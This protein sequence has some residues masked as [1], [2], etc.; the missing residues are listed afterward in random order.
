MMEW[1]PYWELTSLPSPRVL[2][3]HL[4]FWLQPQDMLAKK[5]KIVFYYR[6]FK[7]VA[8]SFYYHHKGIPQYEYNGDFKGH[9]LLMVSGKGKLP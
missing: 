7:D 5:P 8:V 6:N 2:N 3:N 1:Q 4:P 9:L